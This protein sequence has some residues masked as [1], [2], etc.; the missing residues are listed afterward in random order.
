MLGGISCSVKKN[1][2]FSRTYHRT[3]AYFNGYF[4]AKERVK[5]GAKSLADSQKDQYD[6]ILPI[7]KYGDP[8][9]AKAVFPDMDEAIKKVSLVIQRHSMEIDG[10]ERNKWIDDCYLVIGKAQFYKHETGNAIESFQFVAAEYRTKPIRYEALLW[11]TQC[12]LRLGKMPD[13]DYLLTTL[14]GDPNMPEEL[15]WFYNAIF[16]DYHMLNGDIEKAAEFLEKSVLQV[17]KKQQKVRYRFILG[18]IYQ[19]MSDCEKAIAQYDFVL[20]KNPEY[21]MYFNARVNRAVCVDVNDPENIA[22]IREMLNKMLKDEKNID[23]LDQ[24]HYALAK[25]SYNEGDITSSVIS[26]QKSVE[27]SVSNTNQKALSYL[28][29]GEIYFDLPDYPKAE[30]YYD[31]TMTFLSEDYPDYY[32]IQL[33]S[34]NLGNL[35]RNLS[36][37][38]KE[39]SLQNLFSLTPAQREAFVDS[40]I[41]NENRLRRQ[42]AFERMQEEKLLKEQ[43]EA[44]AGDENFVNVNQNRPGV[45]AA[46]AGWYFSNQSAIS[47]G[48][49]EFRKKWGNRKNED[50][51]RRSNKST[52]S[53]GGDEG[54]AN[55]S[56]IDP[57]MDW[58]AIDSVLAVDSLAKR[59]AYLANIPTNTSD[60]DSSTIRI[61]EAYYDNGVIYRESL[62][63]L[64]ESAKTFE[65]LLKKYPEN[66]YKVPTYYNLYRVYLAMEDLEKAEY[67][68]NIIL[69]DYPDSEYA[70]I[71]T[72]PNYFKDQARKVAIQKVFYE[73]T[74]RAYLNKQY[75]DV[76]ERK[77]MADSMFPGGDLAPKFELLYAMAVGRSQPL[78]NFE[79]SLKKVISYY[80]EDSVS[81]RA[82]EILA[83]IN[84]EIYALRD[85]TTAPEG[86]G[87]STQVVTA[88]KSLTPFK[89]QS[90]TTQYLIF[91]YRNNVINTNELKIALSNYNKKY[92][93]VKK[94]KVS[95]LLIGRER[96][97]VMVK[98]YD[99]ARDAMSYID[100][101]V[102]D[103]EAFGSIDFELIKLFAITP[104]NMILLM[105]TKDIS[106]YE[107]FYI[108]NYLV[109]K[110]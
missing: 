31:S 78:P 5:I 104:E 88:P 102:T 77:V 42:Q 21:E 1:N 93:S 65:E 85:S 23:Y 92:F 52:F 7:F 22:E 66:E 73:N 101:M 6:R 109:G 32:K 76:M 50:N 99:N 62:K 84:P 30:A 48:F 2:F 110:K 61:V 38:A 49:T 98:Q 39:D 20:K 25:I 63:N 107:S 86:P 13:A 9:L 96:Q 53:I 83:R 8:Q 56:K 10:E 26:L 80:P 43:E 94:L 44:G 3:T 70:K 19:K 40:I 67:Y 51:W 103:T 59:K 45:Q 16:A 108:A 91:I 47:F 55:Q 57:K 41:A 100:L 35:I 28:M 64:E 27:A 4:N 74:F 90:D 72:N 24:I 68:K 34:T 58:A 37:I 29:L 95:S 82:R 33:L 105:Q 87:D 36:I 60:L 18:Q 75:E 46:T 89:V 97:M 12:Y 15:N 17:K 69:I 54:D 14:N 11:L 106:G 81:I 71:I 79:A